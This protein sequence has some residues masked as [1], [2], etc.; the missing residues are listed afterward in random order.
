M[1]F[2]AGA[3]A[4]YG[5]CIPTWIVIDLLW[6]HDSLWREI[7]SLLSRS[8]NDSEVQAPDVERP[9]RLSVSQSESDP[10]KKRQQLLKHSSDDL[11]V[12]MGSDPTRKMIVVAVKMR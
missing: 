5:S 8:S 7:W 6:W 10:S 12:Q 9:L 2:M 4:K 11:E 1:S 3:S